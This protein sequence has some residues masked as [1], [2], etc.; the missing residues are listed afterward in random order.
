MSMKPVLIIEN[1]TNS[2]SLNES[3]D[4]SGKRKYE[5]SGIFT[6]FDVKNRNE[7]IYT[8]EKFIPCLN[9]LNERIKTFGMVFGEYDHP[10]VFDTS[11]KCTSHIVTTASFNESKNLVEGSIRLLSTKWGK[12]ARSLVEDHCPIFV[13]SR[14]AGITE[15]DGMV[16]LK[17]LFTYDI[18]ADP[19]FSSAKM[20]LSNINESL[21][22]KNPKANFRIYEMSDASKINDVFNMNND[23]L[24]T[25]T[26]MTEYS[27][28]LINEIQSTKAIVENAVKTGT[29]DPSKLNEYIGYYD[30]LR[31]T[32]EKIVKY[33]DY[34]A[35]KL[36]V[37][38]SENDSLKETTNKLIAHNDYIVE[39]MIKGI[40]YTK[41]VAEQ[42]D[43][44]IRYNEYIGENLEKT[45][46]FGDYL[47]ENLDKTIEYTD[48]L[49]ENLNSSI[50]YSQY[51]TEKLGNTIE[52]SNAISEKV[53]D[54]I[55]Y[56]EHVREHVEGGIRY[57]QYVAEQVDDT[58]K[59][60]DY[61]AEKLDN[62][63]SYSKKIVETLNNTK[64]ITES[65]ADKLPMPEEE[66]IYIIDAEKE[67][68]EDK[69]EPVMGDENDHTAADNETPN[70]VE[71]TTETTVVE[72]PVVAT[73][74]TIVEQPVIETATEITTE[75]TAE[76]TPVVAD[77][78]VESTPAVTEPVSTVVTEVENKTNESITLSQKID[79]LITEAKKRKAAETEDIHFLKFLNKSQV[80]NFYAMTQD[81]REKIVAYINEKSNYY[82]GT[83]VLR[84]MNESLALKEEG[85]EEKLVR[86]IPESIKPIWESMNESAK[87]GIFSQA[88]LFPTL[89]NDQAIEHF[90]LTRS[91]K[92]NDTSTKQI[93]NESTKILNDDKLSDSEMNSILARFNSLK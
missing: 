50:R 74:E 75:A 81:D 90:W 7:R 3:A 19:G 68:E 60:S 79:Q 80:D 39:N 22:F 70:V 59:Y 73:T 28:H 25:R 20:N 89:N 48:H 78:V 82:T 52:H 43:N 11:L 62:T 33:L 83:D 14:A 4:S 32:N 15:A 40:S 34:I 85:L 56:V 17:K 36:L 2:L 35:D 67:N 54:T 72:T 55:E 42:L 26:Q 9:E 44:T 21:G 57:V 6:E 10:D 47:A 1:S 30:E 91:L 45:V 63:L 53:E 13:S 23:E 5:M 58:I 24:V 88:K 87:K 31:A 86:L 66:G 51:I 84:L 71:S 12:E 65:M 41:Y 61:I 64:L 49:C 8:A 27:K 92:K 77:P 46:K 18:V 76:T 37:A 38:V 29:M 93:V 16:S 69:K